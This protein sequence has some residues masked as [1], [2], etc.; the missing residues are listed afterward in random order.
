MHIALKES[1]FK[2]GRLLTHGLRYLRQSLKNSLSDYLKRL[3]AADFGGRVATA[4][5]AAPHHIHQTQSVTV[6]VR[7]YFETHLG[8]KWQNRSETGP[9][10]MEKSKRLDA[11][12][13][14]GSSE[15]C[16]T[17]YPPVACG[18]FKTHLGRKWQNRGA[19]GP[20]DM[21]GQRKVW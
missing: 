15:S 7:R 5:R 14:C 4:S 1:T 9:V 13:R 11:G 8:R 10:D 3:D 21:G 18:N 19:T 16:V 17:P 6:I 12:G 20:V 2:Q